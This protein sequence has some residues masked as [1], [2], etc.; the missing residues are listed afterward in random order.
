MKSLK[1]IKYIYEYYGIKTRN[2]CDTQNNTLYSFEI[3]KFIGYLALFNWY[4][5]N[6]SYYKKDILNVLSARMRVY[7]NEYR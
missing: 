7:Y 1:D 6:D 4:W 2:T 3:N 5:T